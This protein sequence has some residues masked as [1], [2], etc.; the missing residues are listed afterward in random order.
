[1]GAATMESDGIT[2][3]ESDQP[4]GKLKIQQRKDLQID[5]INGAVAAEVEQDT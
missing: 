2:E 4:A 1:M 3:E 5:Q